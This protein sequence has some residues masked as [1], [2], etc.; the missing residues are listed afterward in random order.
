LKVALNTVTLTCQNICVFKGA[1]EVW[2]N[3]TWHS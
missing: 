1:V 2:Y 3:T